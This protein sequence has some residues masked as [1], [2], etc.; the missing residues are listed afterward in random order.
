MSKNLVLSLLGHV[1]GPASKVS[2]VLKHS[3]HQTLEVS[4]GMESIHEVTPYSLFSAG[5]AIMM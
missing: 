3:Y 1:P 4:V 2:A 5:L